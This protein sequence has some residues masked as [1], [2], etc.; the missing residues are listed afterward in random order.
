MALINRY[1]ISGLMLKNL[2]ERSRGAGGAGGA[3]GDEGDKG[4]EGELLNKSFLYLSPLPCLPCLFS[5][6]CLAHYRFPIPHS[7]LEQVELL[8]V[9]TNFLTHSNC[10]HKGDGQQPPPFFL[11]AGQSADLYLA[12]RC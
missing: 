6:P 10:N 9:A 12:K 11:I 4:D 3:G 8:P 2:E 5:M 7:L 1:M